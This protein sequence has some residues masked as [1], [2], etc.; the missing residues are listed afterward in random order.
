[1]N[2][3]VKR[4]ERLQSAALWANCRAHLTVT[5]ELPQTL[6]FLPDRG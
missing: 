2:A 3:V 4:P 6:A 5:F 1:M